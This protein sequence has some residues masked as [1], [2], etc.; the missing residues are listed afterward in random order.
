MFQDEYRDLFQSSLSDIS[1]KD[2][3]SADSGKVSLYAIAE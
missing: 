3:L 2:S 1:L